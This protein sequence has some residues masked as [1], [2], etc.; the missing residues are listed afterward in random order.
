MI[1]KESYTKEWIE[2][3][4]KEFPK[5]S[6]ELIERVIMA[7][8]L[9]E[10]IQLNGL[11]FIF[12]GGTSLLLLIKEAH[13]FSI[14]IDI[15]MPEKHINIE[16]IL[17]KVLSDDLFFRF[18]EQ[19]RST[20]KDI[21]KAHYR[22]YYK[23]ALNGSEYPIL[24]DILFE[25]NVYV[26]T[27]ALPIKSVFL[28]CEGEEV[29]VTLPSI[30]CI[31]GDKLTAYAPNTTGIRYGVGKEL[32]IIKQLYDVSKLFNL[33]NNIDIVRDSFSE[34]S[35]KEL[36]YRGMNEL[37]PDDVLDDIFYTSCIIAFRGAK[38]AEVFKE[39]NTG[40]TKIKGYI[41]SENYILESGVL[42]ASKTAYLS[43]LI[44][45][46]S[47]YI[48][49]RFDPKMDLSKLKINNE[50]FRKFDSIKKFS[51]EAFFYWYKAIELLNESESSEILKNL[52]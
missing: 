34:I 30:N 1:S 50:V 13:R 39:L 19:K 25:E 24:L 33:F 22:F 36:G 35:T 31:L 29:N 9:L 42:S 32:E 11:K 43:R 16:A 28:L 46:G 17:N 40:V 4:V 18:E 49:E 26:E 27:N 2:R 10:K 20:S 7:F 41:Y 47:N 21:P 38:K 37:T 12:K 45:S 5:K 51:P 3:K 8:S 15:I 23:S 6:P 48:G 52:A 14:D 44:K